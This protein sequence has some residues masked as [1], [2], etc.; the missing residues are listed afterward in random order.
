VALK[1]SFI[2]VL[3][4]IRTHRPDIEDPEAMILAGAIVVD[5]RIVTNPR[6]LV[7][8]DASLTVRVPARMRGGDK[9]RAALTTFSIDVDGRV[10]LDVGAASGGFTKALLDGGARRV[11][12]VDVGHGQLPG[13]LR[14]D[15]RVV[16]M[17]RTNIADLDTERVPEPLD[18]VTLDLS[19]LSV[20]SAVPQ[21]GRLRFAGSAS[22]VALIKPMF[23]LHLQS[24]P[25]D[26]RLAEA[27]HAASDG[28]TAAGWTVESF[29]PSP[30]RGRRGAVEFLL[31]ATWRP[32]DGSERSR[33]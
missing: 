12:A 16:V 1:R 33:S 15:D 9:L 10:A 31:H 28:V 8:K 32:R 18:V 24:L 26:A 6:G 23:E 14:Q 11:Y 30:V 25:P 29:F 22:L 4:L 17:E 19:Y 20:A 21:L 7:P 27:V 5:G 3:A 13:S 2:S